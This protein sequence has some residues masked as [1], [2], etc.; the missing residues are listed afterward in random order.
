MVHRSQP[1][2]F[3]N[4]FTCHLEFNPVLSGSC[5]ACLVVL[6]K[7]EKTLYSA[8]LGDS[9]FLVIRDGRV[10]HKSREQQHY[11]NAPFQLA[12]APSVLDGTVLSDR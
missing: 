10:V 8:N 7:E 9:G 4:H 11:F 6:D 1:L 2:Y 12:I 5:T 3:R